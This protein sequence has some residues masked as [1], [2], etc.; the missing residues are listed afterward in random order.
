LKL[1]LY[2]GLALAGVGLV[3]GIGGSM[4]V[5]RAMTALLYG[6]GARDPMTMTSVAAILAAVALAACYFPARTAT[7]IDPTVALRCE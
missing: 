1:V 7:Q 6:I 2:R 4:A 3:I 5:T